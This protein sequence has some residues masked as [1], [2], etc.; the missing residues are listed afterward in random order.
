MKVTKLDRPKLAVSILIKSCNFSYFCDALSSQAMHFRHT[1]ISDIIMAIHLKLPMTLKVHVSQTVIYNSLKGN[2]MH[3]YR[4][5]GDCNTPVHP[6]LNLGCNLDI[7][8]KMKGKVYDDAVLKPL[9][10]LWKNV[11]KCMDLYSNIGM[12]NILQISILMQN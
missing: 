8:Q 5:F 12:A 6:Y 9:K 7:S 10:W 2:R 3:S 11:K 4:I 1:E